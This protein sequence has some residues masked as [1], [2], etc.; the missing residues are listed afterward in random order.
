MGKRLHGIPPIAYH[1]SMHYH[2]QPSLR[3]RWVKLFL[4]RIVCDPTLSYYIL[5]LD[6]SRVVIYARL[7][8]INTSTLWDDVI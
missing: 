1:K 7:V 5:Y 8:L 6:W 2:Q 3:F 4:I